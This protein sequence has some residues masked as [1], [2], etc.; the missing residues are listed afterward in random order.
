MIKPVLEKFLSCN[1]IEVLVI[2]K[3]E[4]AIRKINTKQAEYLN[5]FYEYFMDNPKE[6]MPFLETLV[7]DTKKLK[8]FLKVDTVSGPSEGRILALINAICIQ[9]TCL[10]PVSFDYSLS[11][12]VKGIL[13]N[14]TILNRFVGILITVGYKKSEIDE[15][16][17]NK[18]IR[19]AL[20]ELWIRSKSECIIFLLEFMNM[21]SKNTFPLTEK[22]IEEVLEFTETMIFSNE[23]QK[24][25]F[26][27]KVRELTNKSSTENNSNSKQSTNTQ[28]AKMKSID[29]I[30]EAKNQREKEMFNR[31]PK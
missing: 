2:D 24:V 8:K 17:N 22:V 10:R 18:V 19:L 16:S 21:S 12:A 3:T 9:A 11:N 7:I 28:P 25:K 23:E 5:S 4:F 30:L 6:F 20:E 26:L 13:D 27:S 15:F 14:N 1:E 29:E 31:L